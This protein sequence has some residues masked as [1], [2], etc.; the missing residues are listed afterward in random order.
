M[1]L[2]MPVAPPETSRVSSVSEP[3][4]DLVHL[5]RQTDGDWALQQELLALFDRQSASLL[6]QSASRS[7]TKCER[8]DAAH[9]LHGSALAVGAGAV[10][11]AAGALEIALA[12]GAPT[13]EAVETAVRALTVAVDAARAA[14]ARLRGSAPGAIEPILH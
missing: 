14:L 5:E 9:K 13:P 6:A 7:A 12:E 11:R 1:M 4:L 2:A 10:A 3:A 8:A